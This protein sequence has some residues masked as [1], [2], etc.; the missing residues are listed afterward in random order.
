MS[1]EADEHLTVKE[2]AE[3]WGITAR[4]VYGYVRRGM[5]GLVNA[6]EVP[7]RFSRKTAEHWVEHGK[8]APGRPSF[9]S[10]VGKRHEEQRALA[11]RPSSEPNL[12]TSGAEGFDVEG[13]PYDQV[14]LEREKWAAFKLKIQALQLQGKLVPV[15]DVRAE[16]LARIHA[17]KAEL[18]S[19]PSRLASR[20]VGMSE[21]EIEKAIRHAV[22]AACES[23]ARE[24]DAEERAAS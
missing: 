8:R 12:D 3:R 22:N 19:I 14:R 20:L 23:F 11:Q 16:R 9:A 5:P 17:V 2:L 6:N 13:M 4:K 7:K 24:P 21:K 15:E 10:L 1:S 18:A